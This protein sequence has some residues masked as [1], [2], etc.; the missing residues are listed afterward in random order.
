MK[1]LN[2]MMAEF[3]RGKDKKKRKKRRLADAIGLTNRDP[4]KFTPLGLGLTVVP[5]AALG[6]SIGQERADARLINVAKDLDS[7][8]IPAIRDAI[9]SDPARATEAARRIAAPRKTIGKYALG[10]AAIG[11]GLYGG[12]LLARRA[13]KRIKNRNK[14]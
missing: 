11:A 1:S 7:T 3:A 9:K 10:G 8:N 6:A 5:A 14:R 12:E 13:W 4:S 2:R